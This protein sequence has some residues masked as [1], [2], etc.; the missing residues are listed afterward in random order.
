MTV[1]TEDMEMQEFA[2]RPSVPTHQGTLDME[3][4]PWRHTFLHTQHG[5]NRYGTQ[6][7]FEI[8][9]EKHVY[10]INDP[11]AGSPTETLLR[12]LLPLNDQV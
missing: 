3:R 10:S 6:M 4:R 9:A 8:H 2:V 11:S 5:S 12:L 1:Q 7:G